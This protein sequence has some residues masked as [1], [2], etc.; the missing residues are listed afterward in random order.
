MNDLKAWMLTRL[1]A[2]FGI[3]PAIIDL[4]IRFLTPTAG[5]P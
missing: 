3:A 1:M 5:I 4:M 2:M